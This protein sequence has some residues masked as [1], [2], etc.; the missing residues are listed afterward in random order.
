MKWAT[1]GACVNDSFAPRLAG[2]FKHVGCAFDVC[3]IHWRVISH[4]QTVIGRHVK[5]PVAAG[6]LAVQQPK[7][8]NV[9]DNA[10]EFQACQATFV[11]A[12]AKQCLDVMSP[13][14]QSAHDVSS[15]KSRCAC[16][17]AIHV[18]F[19]FIDQWNSRTKAS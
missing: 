9:T 1:N 7:V 15:D 17:K 6:D 8:Q 18:I 2:R 10:L 12:M 11:G 16:D 14:E 3:S 5:A 4:P 13:G 19:G